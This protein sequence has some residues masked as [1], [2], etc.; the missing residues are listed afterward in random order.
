[1]CSFLHVYYLTLDIFYC[2]DKV[3]VTS[4]GTARSTCSFIESTPTQAASLIALRNIFSIIFGDV[5]DQADTHSR[6]V[7][8]I[9]EEFCHSTSHFIEPILFVAKYL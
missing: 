9:F 1:M 4:T 3:L 5:D 2:Q 7:I 6:V 8:C